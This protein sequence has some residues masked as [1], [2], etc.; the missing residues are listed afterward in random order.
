M[1]PYSFNVQSNEYLTKLSV[2]STVRLF[3]HRY[4]EDMV[5]EN[6][7][8][9]QLAWIKTLQGLVQGVQCLAGEIPFF[10][11]SGWIIRKTGHVNCMVLVFCA[12]TIRMFL[13]TV[14]SNLTWI[15]LI[16]LLNGISYALAVTMKMSYAK[17]ISPP[18]T[19]YTIIGFLGFFDCI[20]TLQ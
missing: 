10:F 7:D 2:T 16:E 5:S 14:I 9:N 18:D 8:E 13:Y 12:M 17:S 4:M 6:H 20:G 3:I 15:I 11:C 19:T 1:M